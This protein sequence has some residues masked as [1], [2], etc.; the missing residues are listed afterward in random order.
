MEL[1][2][3]SLL[4]EAS[5]K[6]EGSLKGRERSPLSGGGGEVQRGQEG[7]R[8]SVPFSLT[9]IS[10]GCSL[11]PQPRRL[12]PAVGHR[13]TKTICHLQPVESVGCCL[14]WWPSVEIGLVAQQ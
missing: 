9:V 5:L 1:G 13:N 12:S 14:G 2:G 10:K 6:P 4:P 3:T 8:S 11:T 7:R